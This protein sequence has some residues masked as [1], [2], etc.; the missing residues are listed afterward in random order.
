MTDLILYAGIAGKE[1]LILA[2]G[3][4]GLSGSNIV[5]HGNYFRIPAYQKICQR[6]DFC[7]FFCSG[8]NVYH[9]AVIGCGMSQHK[10][11]PE[12]CMAAK[13]VNRHIRILYKSSDIV[14]YI[15]PEFRL[16]QTFPDIKDFV[17]S[18]RSMKA[19]GKTCINILFSHL[20]RQKPSSVRAGKFHLVPVS[21]NQ[22]GRNDRMNRDPAY[23]PYMLN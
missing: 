16:E 17:K 4:T 10:K 21:E 3:N 6:L 5:Y 2:D 12:S 9:P 8:Y 7:R 18:P 1:Y 13:P 15:I 23:K 22:T 14:E 20:V 11:T 19:D